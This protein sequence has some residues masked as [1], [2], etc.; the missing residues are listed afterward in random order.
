MSCSYNIRTGRGRH[1][2]EQVV[3]WLKSGGLKK[4]V[5]TNTN[6]EFGTRLSTFTKWLSFM[7]NVKME[8]FWIPF[9]TFAPN[10]TYNPVYFH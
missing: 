7:T 5:L 6:E 2:E 10:A 8:E 9:I 3:F 4:K 1:V